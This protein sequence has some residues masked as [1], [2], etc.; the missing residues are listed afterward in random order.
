MISCH[1]T[2][3]LDILKR[4]GE[5]VNEFFH[6]R[7]NFSCNIYPLCV[8]RLRFDCS[9]L[10]FIFI[11]TRLL[12]CYIYPEDCWFRLS[13]PL[14]PFHRRSP[15]KHVCQPPNHPHHKHSLISNHPAPLHDHTAHG[16]H[17]F[18]RFIF[19]TLLCRPCLCLLSLVFCCCLPSHHHFKQSLLPLVSLLL[20]VI[21]LSVYWFVYCS[22]LFLSIFF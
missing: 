20:I 9:P 10:V 15:H 14:F 21:T 19:I 22:H 12:G 5:C 2:L 18:T 3:C 1:P 13:Q 8:S 7:L 4:T 6:R 17:P 11:F 16:T